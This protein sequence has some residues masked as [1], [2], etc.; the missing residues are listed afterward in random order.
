MEKERKGGGKRR[1]G[2]RGR[3]GLSFNYE[4]LVWACAKRMH[5]LGIMAEDDD[6]N[7]NNNKTS[8]TA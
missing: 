7:N 5:S 1:E 6:D 2:R 8:A 3:F 4:S